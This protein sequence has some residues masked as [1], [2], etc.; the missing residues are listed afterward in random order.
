MQIESDMLH[1]D[2]LVIDEQIR[3]IKAHL[4]QRK[5]QWESDRVE[6]GQRYP[7]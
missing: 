4:S 7:N 5:E 6:A 3:A 1:R 2:I